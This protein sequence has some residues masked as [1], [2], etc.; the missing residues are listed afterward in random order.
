[1]SIKVTVRSFVGALR[2][3][4]TKKKVMNNTDNARMQTFLTIAPSCLDS[5]RYPPRKKGLVRSWLNAALTLY[6]STPGRI[7]LNCI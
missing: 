7:E 3:D 4:V 2:D 6:L 1:M 5:A